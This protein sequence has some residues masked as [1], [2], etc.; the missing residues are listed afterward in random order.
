M[1]RK[2][3][4]PRP[5]I[6]WILA[7]ALVGPPVALS[8]FVGLFDYVIMPIFWLNHWVAVRHGIT[9]EHAINTGIAGV[10]VTGICAI[11]GTF[12]AWLHAVNKRDRRRKQI[13][14]RRQELR[15]KREREAAK[16][17]DEK[18]RLEAEERRRAN[19]PTQAE[20][21][22]QARGLD[23]MVRQRLVPQP[24]FTIDHYHGPRPWL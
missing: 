3:Y 10:I 22:M 23:Q 5:W 9:G 8:F 24:R 20:I 6:L 7:A 13:K 18:W 21:E 19:P 15:W 16:A 4:D 14:E 12:A 2:Q 11:V 1:R 17:Q